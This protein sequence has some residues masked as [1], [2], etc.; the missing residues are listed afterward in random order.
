MTTW[1]CVGLAALLVVFSARAW[2]E[3]VWVLW[4][5]MDQVG[6]RFL[7]SKS[8]KAEANRV[9]KQVDRNVVTTRT[10]EV[11]T[12]GQWRPAGVSRVRF[13]CLSDTIDPRA[14]RGR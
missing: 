3:R 9:T 10:E 7:A 11:D 1:R 13:V 12:D 8:E 14:P 5:D 4:A 2:A 6:G